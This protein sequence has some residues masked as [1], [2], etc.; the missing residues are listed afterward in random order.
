MTDLSDITTG[1]E[2]LRKMR[3][4]LVAIRREAGRQDRGELSELY[5]RCRS[6]VEDAL[7][8]AMTN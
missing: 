1:N 2:L 4:L 8:R 7:M 3:D 6:L 5:E